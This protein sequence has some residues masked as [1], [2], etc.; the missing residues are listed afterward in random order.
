MRAAYADP[1][2]LG[3]SEKFYGSMHPNARDYDKPE[4]HQELINMLCADFDAW[5]LSLHEPSLSTILPM[6]PPDIRVAAWV[7]PFASFKKNVMRAWTWEPVIFRFGERKLPLGGTTWR[8]HIAENIAMKKGFQGA[9]PERF[10]FWVFEGLGLAPDD[11]FV[12]LFPGSGAVSA[13]WDKWAARES[14]FTLEL[15]GDVG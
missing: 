4:K 2:Y 5:A 15:F 10:C 6:C 9:K 1:P 12:D 7:K 14:E 13:A 8:D 11:E 3:M